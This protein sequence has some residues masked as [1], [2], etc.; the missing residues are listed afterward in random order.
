MK[1]LAALT[2]A[3]VRP[4]EIEQFNEESWNNL[5]SLGYHTNLLARLYYL[6][7]REN[8]TH[9]IPERILWHFE[10]SYRMS[11][12][13]SRDVRIEIGKIN[14]ALKQGGIYPIFLKGAAYELAQDEVS[15]GRVYSDVDI[16]VPRYEIE[17]AEYILKL[18]GWSSSQL[19]PYDAEYYRRWMHEIPPLFHRGRGATLDVHH[20]LLPLTCRIKIDDSK[21]IG[22]RDPKQPQVLMVEDRILH[23][24]VHLFMEGEFDKGLRDLSDLDMLL[25]QHCVGEPDS[26]DLISA[27]AES[28]GVGR[29]W[30]YALKCCHLV[31]NTP[32]PANVLD[33]CQKKFDLIFPFSSILLTLFQT[34]LTISPAHSKGRRYAIAHFI[35]YLRGHW[36]RMP[37]TLLVPHLI[38]KALRRPKDKTKPV[39]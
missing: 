6:F 17:A 19:D 2:S 37:L 7:E 9:F 35:M 18:H 32:I 15:F 14:R 22:S 4:H 12:A 13:H 28:L 36:L 3:L 24:V 26:W 39:N 23:A 30:F 5:I 34:V 29:L 31:F 21:L 1:S 16:F 27:R 10:S 33:R 38:R 20:N 8:I 25:R 11:L